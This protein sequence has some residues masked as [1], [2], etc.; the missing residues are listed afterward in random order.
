M[1]RGRKHTHR[2]FSLPIAL[3]KWLIQQAQVED[4]PVSRIIKRALLRYKAEIER[5]HPEPSGG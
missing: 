4:R 2:N 1:K 5:A 3:D